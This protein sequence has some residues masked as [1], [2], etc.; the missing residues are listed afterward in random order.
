MLAS[1]IRFGSVRPQN[2]EVPISSNDSD[3]W[4]REFF[5]SGNQLGLND[6]D[7]LTVWMLEWIKH[8]EIR[9]LWFTYKR[10][11]NEKN[12][13]KG[14]SAH[15]FVVFNRLNSERKFWGPYKWGKIVQTRD[16]KGGLQIRRS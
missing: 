12:T 3:K 10:R 13:N 8:P 11:F 4:K 15:L 1:M 14:M 2:M 5:F 6:L 9:N 7:Y 16:G